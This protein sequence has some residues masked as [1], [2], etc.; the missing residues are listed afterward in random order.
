MSP[1]GNYSA[2]K[3]CSNQNDCIDIKCSTMSQILLERCLS[4][5]VQG[6][7]FCM[8]IGSHYASG[9]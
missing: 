1:L 5:L 9:L 3:Q 4:A 8:R 6:Q 2:K 7:G